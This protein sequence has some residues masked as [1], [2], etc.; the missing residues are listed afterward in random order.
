MS[1]RFDHLVVAVADLDEAAARWRNAGLSAT[2]G[3]AHPVGTENA[4]VRGPKSA[5]VELI[6]A[7]SDGSNPWLDRV[8]SAGGPISWAIAVDDVDA[9]RAAL[10]E[11]GFDPRPVTEGSRTTPDGSVVGWRMCDVGPGPYD[12]SLPFLIQ[13]T[14][15][16]PPGP[17]EGPVV[18]WV[19]L[20][21]PDPD[22]LADLL[23]A[24]GFVP[25]RPWPR[26]VFHPADGSASITL[27]PVGQPEGVDQSSWSMSWK[28][29]DEPLVSIALA[30]ASGE[31]SRL[32]LD[33]VVV[34]TRTDRRRFAA[35]SLLPAVDEAFTWL[36][37]DL[38]DWPNPHTAGGSPADDE[39]SRVTDP[40]RY[41]LLAVRADAWVEVIVDAGLGVVEQLDPEAVQWVVDQHLVPTRVSVL[42]GPEGAQPIVVLIAAEE[43][44]VQVG[45]GQPVEL[46]DRQPDCGC[47]ACDTGSA[48]LLDT[49]DSAFVLAL[50]GGVYVVRAS[51]TSVVQRSLDGWGSTNVDHDEAERWLAEA[52]DGRR[53]DGVVA[54]EA[55]L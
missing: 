31:L 33:G 17:A 21:P 24:V 4:L 20:T 8:R 46:L 53:T 38:A 45:V 39:Y 37:G 5:Y 11:A 27:N 26:R 19:S 9:S 1:A 2:R 32:T 43:T 16:M 28:E 12:A 3:G 54:G 14:T 48:D 55:W 6:A 25:S 44:V 41:R 47:D 7:G 40:E 42:R 23:V 49:V 51:T 30:V 36:R 34:A 15:P 10:V 18:E 52:A 50:S 22:R 29:P 13:W 35:S